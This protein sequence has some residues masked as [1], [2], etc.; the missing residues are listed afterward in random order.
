MQLF[1][2]EYICKKILK[3]YYK[4]LFPLVLF[5]FLIVNTIFFD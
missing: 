1:R 4:Y 5:I 2:N 3:Y